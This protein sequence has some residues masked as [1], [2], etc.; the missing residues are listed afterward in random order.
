MKLPKTGAEWQKLVDKARYVHRTVGVYEEYIYPG[1]NYNI[2]FYRH[3]VSFDCTFEKPL[4]MEV[5][6][7]QRFADTEESRKHG[8][9]L[10]QKRLIT[11]VQAL[12][13]GY[14]IRSYYT[15]VESAMNISMQAEKM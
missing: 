1:Y 3:R 14:K 13:R 5:L 11:S 4:K 9:T 15:Y 7:N 8:C 2:Y 12:Y 6:D 10:V